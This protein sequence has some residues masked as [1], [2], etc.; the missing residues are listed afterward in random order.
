MTLE[1]RIAFHLPGRLRRKAGRVVAC[2]PTLDVWTQGGSEAEAKRNLADAVASF[3]ES[4]WRR[5][6][7]DEVL[8]SCGWGPRRAPGRIR[9]DFLFEVNLPAKHAA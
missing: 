3:L 7:L 9:A 6:T 1:P 4:C 5:G 8:R 2:C